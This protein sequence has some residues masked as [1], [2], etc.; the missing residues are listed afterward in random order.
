MNNTFYLKGTI[1]LTGDP[2]LVKEHIH[3]TEPMLDNMNG[4]RFLNGVIKNTEHDYVTKVIY[5]FLVPDNMRIKGMSTSDK[6][7]INDELKRFAAKNQP[8]PEE[9]RLVIPFLYKVTKPGN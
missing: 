7:Y 4:Y 2:D 1:E 3:Q 9:D 5:P 8:K 6:V